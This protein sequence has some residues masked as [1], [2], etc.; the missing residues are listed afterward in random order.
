MGNNHVFKKSGFWLFLLLILSSCQKDDVKQE[1]FHH[2][3]NEKLNHKMVTAAD[4]PEVMKF[5]RANSSKDLRFTIHTG[6]IT[7]GHNR[8][9]E[10]DLIISELMTE[11]ILAVTNASS[12]TNYSFQLR[13]DTAPYYEG[14]VSFF[15]LIVKETTAVEGYYAYIQEYRMDENWYVGNDYI[16]DMQTYT[17]K[18][19]F[20][21]LEG[22]Y[23][24]KVDFS[25]GQIIGEDLRSRC[26]DGGGGPGGGGSTSG[27]GGDSGGSTGG[28]GGTGGGTGGGGIQIIVVGCTCFTPPSS[29]W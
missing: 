29:T 17:G 3:S 26:P 1:L 9:G 6:S 18:M 25:N 8:S 16:L 23:V 21:T 24:A 10:P 14:E 19:I 11:Q 5:L 12:L 15:N 28:S 22:L 2:F 13:V 4:I 27:P 20:Y 7:G